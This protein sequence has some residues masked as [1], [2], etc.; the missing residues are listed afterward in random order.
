MEDLGE[1]R[2]PIPQPEFSPVQEATQSP[3]EG[4][5]EGDEPG[6]SRDLQQFVMSGGESSGQESSEPSHQSF[7]FTGGQVS[8]SDKGLLP[9]QGVLNCQDLST[10]SS[11]SCQVPKSPA[12]VV[13][14]LPT[15]AI[16][17]LSQGASNLS[18]KD[19][20]T[21]S[22]AA[23]RDEVNIFTPK[24]WFLECLSVF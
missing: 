12:R 18:F 23:R 4:E 21:S 10:G 17:E 2:S 8:V 11:I 7:V 20:A 19:V 14:P 22:P 6:S 24:C 5:G 3:G 16:S 9:L 15:G 1:G 13:A